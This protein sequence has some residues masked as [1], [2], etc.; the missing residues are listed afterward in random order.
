M[1]DNLK[2]KPKQVNNK[3]DVP[4][5]LNKVNKYGK[6]VIEISIWERIVLWFKDTTD[7]VIEKAVSSLVPSWAW[8]A[9]IGAIVVIL[10][11]TL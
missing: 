10:F 9:L 8:I 4:E 7:Y 3:I 1:F 6:P 11:F 5:K 2:H